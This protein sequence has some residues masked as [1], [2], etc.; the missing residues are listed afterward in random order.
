[1]NQKKIF[2]ITILV[3]LIGA[4]TSC[5]EPKT[6]CLDVNAVNFDVEADEECCISEEEC[7][8]NYP[9][10]S[11]SIDPRLFPDSTDNF[12]LET[13]Y[14][15]DEN[16]NQIF[17]VN[18]I[19]FYLTDFQ[20]VNSI[21]GAIA[22]IR[23][24]ITL[25]VANTQ[26]SEIRAYI[27]SDNF[28]LINRRS[29]FMYEIGSLDNFGDFDEIHFKIGLDS[30]INNTIPDNLEVTHPLSNEVDS[31]HI[32]NVDG[33]VFNRINLQRDT[34]DLTSKIEIEITDLVPIELTLIDPI[35][36]T[37]GTSKEI[38]LRINYLEWFK[39]INFAVNSEN[40]IKQS[41]VQN[42]TNVFEYFE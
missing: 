31:M 11:L 16:P 25:Q 18:D 15:V 6:G 24:T 8:C 14:T 7:C 17:Q 30:L 29:S 27:A 28:S 22:S 35:S 41:I 42:T 2:Q 38:K 39:G 3:F 23:E 20:L 26:T 34:A 37:I 36:V 33:Y 4:F 19:K 1:M 32:D 12:N 21:T 40:E 9:K 10:L 5:Y 13:G